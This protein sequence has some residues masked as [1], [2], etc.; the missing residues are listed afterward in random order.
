MPLPEFSPVRHHDRY[1]SEG[2]GRGALGFILDVLD[3]GYVVEFS[4]PDGTTIAWFYVESADVEPAPDIIVPSGH[5][6][7]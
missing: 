3:E 2:V 4:R 5:L 7:A 6:T 1:L